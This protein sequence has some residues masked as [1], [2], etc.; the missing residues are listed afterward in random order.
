MLRVQRMV[1]RRFEQCRTL[2]WNRLP[3]CVEYRQG[4]LTGAET[5]N[6]QCECAGPGY[7]RIRRARNI[8]YADV[9][10]YVSQLVLRL[11]ERQSEVEALAIEGLQSGPSEPWDKNEIEGIRADL[12]SKYGN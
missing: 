5:V 3:R 12:K 6:D 11:A 10:D 2:G 7:V 8:G 9:N 4:S 1:H